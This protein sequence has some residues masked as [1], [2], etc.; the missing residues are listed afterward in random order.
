MHRNLKLEPGPERDRFI[1]L[2]KDKILLQQI[3]LPVSYALY[4]WRT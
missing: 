3:R 4:Q 1:K 2:Q